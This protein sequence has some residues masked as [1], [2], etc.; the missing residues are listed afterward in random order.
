MDNKKTGE[1]IFKLRAEKELTQKQLADMLNISDKAV[2][3][4]E[5]GQ[6]LPD[7]SLL[8]ELGAIFGVNIEGLLDG[9]LN[10]N[11]FA[12]G[13]MRKVKFYVCPICGNITICTGNAEITCCSRKVREVIPRK[14]DVSHTLEISAVEDEWFISS[15]HAMLK[16]HY[17]SFIAFVSDDRLQIIK[18]YPEWN[19]AARIPV[20]R[21]G[22]IL[23]YCTND[24][25]FYKNI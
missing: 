24:G 20:L 15:P 22:V 2:S 1:L 12:T 14:A 23:W 17:I 21:H 16:E 9:G 8:P 7:V 5:R 18:Q 3:K 4:W 11:D 19:L 13:N 10:V 6:G 25:L